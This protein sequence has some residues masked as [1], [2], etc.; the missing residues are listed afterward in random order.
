[1]MRLLFML[2]IGALAIADTFSLDMSMGPGLSVK[3][4]LIYP[5]ALGLLFRMALTGRFRLRLPVL[6]AAFVIWVTYAILTWIAIVT[7]IHYPG[8][9]IRETGISLKALLMDSAIFFFTFFYGVESERDFFVL[10]KTLAFAVGMANILT[11]A[12]VAGIIHLGI[13]VGSSGVEEG[14]VFGV[15][16]HA[17]DTG[18]L[19]VCFLP[20]LTAVATSSRGWMKVFWYASALASIVVLM[21]T[22]SRGAYV[23]VAIG[24]AWGVWLCRRYLPTSRVVAWVLIG[25]SSLVLAVGVAAAVM[26]DF[27][28]TLTERLLN[29]SMAVSVATASSG[30]TSLWLASVA[31]M[32]AHPITFLTGFGWRTHQLMFTLV[33][34]NFYLDQWFEL[35]LVGLL[36]LLTI[37]YQTV[38]TAL[39]AVAAAEAHLRPYMIAL[40][41]G[42]L[43]L[44]VAIFFVN[45]ERP[46]DYI[47]IYVGFTLRAA[48]E[49]VEKAQSPMKPAAHAS[50]AP[51]RARAVRPR[52]V[53]AVRR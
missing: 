44:A 37:F 26:P 5:I 2:V 32:A 42:M 29:Q 50:G 49:A 4:A 47:W 8:Y 51:A 31:V 34:H 38:S 40:V 9:E 18:A 30:R 15:F 39:R 33:T 7:V 41:F 1:M 53:G 6:N 48:V 43:G 20:M 36:A 13:T 11:L 3:N 21:L 46:W 23:A 19:I 12:D 10:T 35:G 27:V 25:L 45:L 17:N 52:L 28:Q 16:G 24:Y 14:R 22:V